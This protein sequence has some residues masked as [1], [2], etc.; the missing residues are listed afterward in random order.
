MSVFTVKGSPFADEG[1]RKINDI[2]CSKISPLSPCE[3]G[4]IASRVVAKGSAVRVA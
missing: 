4:Y 3:A 1:L 2:L